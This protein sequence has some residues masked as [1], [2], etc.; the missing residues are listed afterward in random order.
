[1]YYIQPT[2]PN[3]KFKLFVSS[4]TDNQGDKIQMGKQINSLK[5]LKIMLRKEKAFENAFDKKYTDEMLSY[6]QID[7]VFKK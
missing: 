1:M 6:K 5:R 7:D 2:V 4:I 3:P